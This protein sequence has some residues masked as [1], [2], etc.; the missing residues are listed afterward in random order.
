MPATHPVSQAF[1]L[2]PSCKLA[3]K[4]LKH[5]G[6]GL[7]VCNLG[8]SPYLWVRGHASCCCLDET[9]YPATLV[10]AIVILTRLIFT[11]CRLCQITYIPYPLLIFK[12]SA[13]SLPCLITG[14]K[15]LCSCFSPHGNIATSTISV[16]SLCQWIFFKIKTRPLWLHWES[17]THNL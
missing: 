15:C 11:V 1:I 7:H 14:Q 8:H 10:E 6:I 5:K 2:T 4:V 16:A 9:S 17:L 12:I 13:I 3:K